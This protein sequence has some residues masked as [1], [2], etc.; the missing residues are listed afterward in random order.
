M[1]TEL[2][3]SFALWASKAVAALRPPA[4][5]GPRLRLLAGGAAPTPNSRNPDGSRAAAQPP[6]LRLACVEG[7]PVPD[8]DTAV[9]ALPGAVA[10]PAAASASRLSGGASSFVAGQGAR[11]YS[12]DVFR[13]RTGR[14]PHAA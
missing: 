11:L 12:L 6:T 13:G 14:T 3:R 2:S 8:R 1:L 10:L 4:A 9:R 5:A 7:A